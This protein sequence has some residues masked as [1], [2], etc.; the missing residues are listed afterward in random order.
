MSFKEAFEDW[1]KTE[2]VIITIKHDFINCVDGNTSFE[3]VKPILEMAFT[4]GY[5]ARKNLEYKKM[6][7][8]P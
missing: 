4:A 1:L 8:I 2:E 5:K 6:L 3:D 7:N